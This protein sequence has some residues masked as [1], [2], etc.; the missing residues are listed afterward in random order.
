MF[1]KAAHPLQLVT[2]GRLWG[3]PWAG[4]YVWWL[5][6]WI[7]LRLQICWLSLEPAFIWRANKA[8]R[9]TADFNSCLWA[10]KEILFLW[11]NAI[12]LLCQTWLYMTQFLLLTMGVCVFL[13]EAA[14]AQAQAEERR[15]LAGNSPGPTTNAPAKPQGCR[16][17][18]WHHTL[19]QRQIGFHA[20]CSVTTLLSSIIINSNHQ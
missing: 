4:G 6:S 9:K 20:Y 18:K 13:H 1:L 16:P 2:D 15:S 11:Y 14:A 3:W 10:P 8:Q 19:T 7:V 5:N 12:H 17:G